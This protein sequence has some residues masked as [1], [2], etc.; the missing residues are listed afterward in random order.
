MALYIVPTP[1]G[2]LGDMTQRAIAILNQVDFVIAE[3]SRYTLKLLNHLGIT[4]KIV[5]HYRPKEEIQAQ[6]I[7]T[8]LA[9]RDAALVTDSGTPGISDP[10]F[11]LIRRAIAAGITIIP[12]PGPTALIPALVASGID[13]Q[14][15]VFLGFPPRRQNDMR[16]FFKSLAL[17][18][19]TLVFYESPRRIENFLKNAAETLNDRHFALAKELSKKHEKII[20]G[21]LDQWSELLKDET[22]LGEMVII[23]SANPHPQT[24]EP[25]P[26]LKSIED[27]YAYFLERHG[28]RKNEL[29][30]IIMK[31]KNKKT[32]DGPIHA[33]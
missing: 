10:G 16:R 18:P 23:I 15:F 9:D 32:T 19:Y 7:V 5:S 22:I 17:L 11:I 6:K 29:K 33:R 12:L 28:L 13:P 20:R 24:H 2:N 30:R 25:A 31:K 14:P 21:R 4:K 3:D 27:V 1:I 8:M 26:G